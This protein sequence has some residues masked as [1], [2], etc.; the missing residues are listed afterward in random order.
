MLLLILPL[1]VVPVLVLAAV[2]YV[3]A[4]REAAKTSARYLS[5]RE[6]DLRTLAENPAI[7]NYFNNRAYGLV[8]EAEVARR[9]LEASLERFAD[10]SNLVDLVYPQVRYVDPDGEEIAKV[11]DGQVRM[12]RT[13]LGDAPFFVAARAARPGQAYLS[14]VATQMTYAM[15]VYQLTEGQPS[16]FQGAVVLDFVY[17]VADF[18]RTTAVIGWTFL[19]ITASSLGIALLV[20]LTRVRRLTGPIHRLAEAAN[21]I[22]AGQRSVAVAIESRDEIGQLGNAFN[23]MATSL[24]ENE[25]ALRRKV[26]ETQTLYEIGQEISAQVELQPTLRLIVARAR[27]FL[28]GEEAILA[29]REGE[30][31]AFA[32]EAHS[33]PSAAPLAGRTFRAGDGSVGGR[34]AATGEAVLVHDAFAELQGDP[35][36]PA[37]RDANAGVRSYLAAPLRARG[38]V[39]G[40]LQVQSRTPSAFREDDRQLLGALAD[41]AVIAIENARLFAEVR[42]HAEELEIKVDE[43]TQQLQEANQRLETASRHKSEFLASMSHELRTPLNAIIGFTRLVLRRSRDVLATRQAENLEKILISAE[44]LLALINDILD[45]SKVEAGR[46]EVRAARFE[47]EPLVDLCLRTVEPMVK[48]ERV[49]LVKALPLGL[50]TL[51]SDEDKLRQI[52]INLLSNAIKFTETGSVTVKARAGAGQVAITVSDTGIGIPGDKLELIFEEFRQADAGTTRRYGGTGLGLSISRH[53][54]RLLGGDLTVAST[55]GAGSAFT[56]TLPVEAPGALAPPVPLGADRRADG[57]ASRLVL[58]IDDDP[59]VIYLLDENLRDSGYRVLGAGTGDEGLRQARELQPFAITLDIML[60]RRDGWSVLHA[61]KTD[62]A[63]RDI[64]VIV[65]SIVDNRELG[66]RLGA[67]DYLLKPFDRDVIL[68]TLGRLAPRRGRLLVVDDDP[69]VADLV[70]QLLEGEPYEITAAADGA[71]GLELVAKARPDLILLDL[72]MPRMDGFTFIERLR[73]DPGARGI[74]VVVLTALSPSASEVRALADR[75]HA[76]VQK[77]GLERDAFLRDLAGALDVHRRSSGAQN[78]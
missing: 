1:V 29:L 54:A 55:F 45:L 53:L 74:P 2:G 22:A 30:G 72:M 17:P 33:G 51:V 75:V 39:L 8:E 7:T 58:A 50:P 9:E 43:R 20:T 77:V 19:A 42:H 27:D 11:A 13:R 49:R 60:P 16:T 25:A 15:P 46:M 32:V 6:T 44:H 67:V 59:D 65:L 37:A 64:P 62:P 5:Q 21:R 71:E 35:M 10:R 31:G 41:Q 23:G 12:D 76:I 4:S 61:L 24:T 70:R 36:L 73:Q 66:F 56:V 38:V 78:R 47:L 68:G 18:Q 40:V 52:L 3:T 28:Q 57:E 48:P 26:G 14:P 69:Q 34:V 63:T